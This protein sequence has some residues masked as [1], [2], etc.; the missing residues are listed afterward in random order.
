M[1]L[2]LTWSD[3][4]KKI[5]TGNYT[6]LTNLQLYTFYVQL[7]LAIAERMKTQGACRGI[8]PSGATEL[9]TGNVTSISSDG[10]H[11]TIYCENEDH[12]APDWV[13]GSDIKRWT[14]FSGTFNGHELSGVYA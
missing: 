3:D 12:T 9:A 11:I 5:G 1:S 6:D 8:F 13:D 4:W 2:P 10:T 14:G 7:Y